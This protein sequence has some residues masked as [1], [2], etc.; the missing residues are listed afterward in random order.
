MR[1]HTSKMSMTENLRGRGSPSTGVHAFRQDSHTDRAISFA[2]VAFASSAAVSCMSDNPRERT[3]CVPESPLTPPSFC[4]T[5]PASRPQ[6]ATLPAAQK[7]PLVSGNIRFY[8]GR[9]VG[10]N[11]KR[12]YIPPLFPR[13]TGGSSENP[14]NRAMPGKGQLWTAADKLK[15]ALAALEAAKLGIKRRTGCER[16][17]ASLGRPFGS[18]SCRVSKSRYWW[19]GQWRVHQIECDVRILSRQLR[20]G[21]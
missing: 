21:E 13:A 14:G 16:M 3:L 18:V 1:A 17:A 4:L 11:A 19:Q 9:M 8:I 15:L 10:R 6:A 5:S 20:F 12:P 7:S 2:C